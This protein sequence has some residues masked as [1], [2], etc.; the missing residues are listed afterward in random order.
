[1][2]YFS[3][4]SGVSWISVMRFEYSSFVS[5]SFSKQKFLCLSPAQQKQFLQL[6]QS[7]RN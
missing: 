7:S 4:S 2:K 5:C 3:T 1:M 6:I